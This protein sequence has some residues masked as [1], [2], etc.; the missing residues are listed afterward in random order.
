MALYDFSKHLH[1]QQDLSS[2][3]IAL[4]GGQHSFTIFLWQTR[5]LS[6]QGSIIIMTNIRSVL[7]RG[8]VLFWILSS[9]N[10]FRPQKNSIRQVVLLSPWYR[11][12]SEEQRPGNLTQ[13]DWAMRRQSWDVRPRQSGGSIQV[14]NITLQPP[15]QV[16][17][18]STGTARHWI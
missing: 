6:P 10:S 3:W 9:T 15:P 14:S 2:S 1:K 11:G 16:A 18:W 4:S 8:Q 12:G 5:T 7:T 17:P 13:G